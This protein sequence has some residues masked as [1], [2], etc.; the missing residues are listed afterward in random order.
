MSDL[1][2]GTD[3]EFDPP[4][5]VVVTFK[6]GGDNIYF[7][8]TWIHHREGWTILQ[9]EEGQQHRHPDREIFEV[10]AD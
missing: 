10:K 6:I 4:R 2:E 7:G 3:Y 9:G 5:T 1:I 8:I